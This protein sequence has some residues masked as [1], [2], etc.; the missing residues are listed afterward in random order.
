MEQS[1]EIW[2]G[3]LPKFG[4]RSVSRPDVVQGNH[5]TLV[6]L[7][8]FCVTFQFIGVCFIVFNLFSRL[9]HAKLVAE[10]RLKWLNLD[11]KP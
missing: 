2:E 4:A 1:T 10:E 11:I 8:P 7:C 3:G 5:L 6:L 9:Y